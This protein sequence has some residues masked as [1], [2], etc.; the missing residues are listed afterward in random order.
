MDGTNER[1][2]YNPEVKER[3][4]ATFPNPDTAKTLRYTFYNTELFEAKAQKD[5][6]DMN[7]IELTKTIRGT[8][9]LNAATAGTTSR[10]IYA[11][12]SWAIDVGLRFS[13][14]HPMDG[15]MT[16]SFFEKL[17]DKTKKIHFSYDELIEMLE[18]IP[19][20][21]DKSML[22]LMF[23]GVIG[24]TFSEL[25]SLKISDVNMDTN[26]VYIEQ[27]DQTIKVDPKCIEFIKGAIKETT[28]QS[29]IPKENRYNEKELLPSQYVFKN[30]KSPRVQEDYQPVSPTVFYNRLKLIKASNHEIEYLTPNALRQS[31]MIKMAVDLVLEKVKNGDEAEIRYRDV[32]KPIGEKYNY[33][34]FMNGIDEYFN[35]TLMSEFINESKIKELYD[36]D[37]TV[38]GKRK[39]K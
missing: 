9:P 26:E 11:Y 29:Y 10:F 16:S 32:Y 30:V 19:N 28:Y 38:A 14:I 35:T 7:L 24:E 34:T 12:I 4:L 23:E 21:Q 20:Y 18:E 5:L 3:Y 17:V 13:N 8:N 1:S 37:V 36:L 25:L 31:G 39:S 33:A 2:L 22:L 15:N 27:R 6:Y